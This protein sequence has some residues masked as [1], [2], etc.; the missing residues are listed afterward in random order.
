MVPLSD[1]PE[2]GKARIH[3]G[4]K[5]SSDLPEPDKV[6]IT[7][8]ITRIPFKLEP[9]LP[10]RSSG[11]TFHLCLSLHNPGIPTYYS[12]LTTHYSLLYL[13]LHNPGI[14]TYCSLL[15]LIVY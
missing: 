9:P 8:D 2:A 11:R 5:S 10:K 3:F 7:T 1:L 6:Y 14:P 13:S 12:L 15:F 4:R